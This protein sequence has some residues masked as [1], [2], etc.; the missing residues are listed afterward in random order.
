M[1][2]KRQPRP[3]ERFGLK[4][5]PVNGAPGWLL[6]GKPYVPIMGQAGGSALGEVRGGR[7]WLKPGVRV[8]AALPP[9]RAG[10][11][12]VACTL[13]CD[14]PTPPQG[15]CY[16]LLEGRTADGGLKRYSIV[17]RPGEVSL[18]TIHSQ[19][20]VPVGPPSIR[21][22]G[23]SPVRLRLIKRQAVLCLE[24]DGVS[25]GRWTD[26]EPMAELAQV[27][28]AAHEAGGTA[29]DL[30]VHD[31]AGRTILAEGFDDATSAMRRF[32]GD[33]PAAPDPSSFFSAGCA[34]YT[35]WEFGPQLRRAWQ[36]D[37]SYDWSE[38]DA[39]LRKL[40]ALDPA[41]RLHGRFRFDAPDW[42][43]SQ[44]PDQMVHVRQL[45]G[46]EQRTNVVSFASESYWSAAERAARDLVRFCDG[47]PEG[48][49]FAAVRYSGGT[50]EW[51]P[52]W[53]AGYSDYSPVFLAGFRAWLRDRYGT[54]R[55]LRAAWKQ[56][57]VALETAELPTPEER[58]RGDF[59]EFYD[60][61]RGLQRQDFCLY[62][63]EIVTR[64]IGRLA[65]AFKEASHGRL[66]TRTPAGYQPG[67]R[68]F[69][70]HSGPHADF[71]SVLKCPWL[72]SFF[73]PND[74]RGR[75]VNGFTAF[76]IPL[77]SVLIHGKTYIAEIDDRTHHVESFLFGT[78]PTAWHTAQALKRTV[79]AALCQASGTEFKDWGAGWF[80]DDATMPVIRRLN[81]LAQESVRH[82]RTPTAQI[83]VILNPRSTCHV[84][85][86]SLLYDTLNNQQMAL[87]YPRI[88]AP[89]DRLLV[90]DLGQARDYKMYIVQ[91]AMYLTDAQRRLIKRTIC[92]K[93]HTVLWIYAPGV[94]G[95]RN[96]GAENIS[97][98]VGMRVRCRETFEH[99]HLHLH[100]SAGLHP[101]NRGIPP[102]TS[103]HTW[104]GL[105]PLF[106]VDDPSVTVLGWGGD[107]H[108]SRPAFAVKTMPDW[109]SVYCSVPVLP[110][111]VIRNIAREA[112]VHIYSEMDDF[113][114]ANNWLLTLCA[115]NDGTRTIRLP[116]RA[117]VRDAMTGKT[118]AVGATR[119]AARMRFGETR[120]WRM[121]TER[122]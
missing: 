51:F 14:G 57:T 20:I 75:G 92:A 19:Q 50:C 37:G 56:E 7:L 88:G 87:C 91:D 121:E 5:A 79:S 120:I 2:K 17:T 100:L 86:D 42:W 34:L 4:V 36:A 8:R 84:R 105:Y 113:V 97:K 81:A 52:H 39:Y 76:E 55:K 90:D 71:A 65:R 18:G 74:Y 62:S 31:G 32:R 68:G 110:P 61:A 77:A 85:D 30:V 24:A 33:L 101:Y 64:L 106:Y 67:G 114:A 27:M 43:I 80:E 60:P 45:G 78:T 13:A 82:D 48:W 47:H 6:D 16:V 15:C 108:N 83:A 69:R 1:K 119:W 122:L 66:L 38:L 23:A 46:A 115:S 73:M 89:H 93:G 26:P 98:L 104:E 35:T 63:S 29:D 41:G 12:S 10:T 49:R 103:L 44:H 40:A 102:G 95:E 96:V 58:V 109:I 3:S 111:A 94:V 107:V 72:D 118:V 112:G 116:R 25:L 99:L 11:F 70:Y 9:A 59:Y 21:G 53:G 54:D 22:P 117:T 28:V